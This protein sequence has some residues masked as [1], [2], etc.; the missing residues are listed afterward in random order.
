MR[1]QAEYTCD[2]LVVG[3]GLA[4][5]RG[6]ISAAEEGRSVLL[7]TAG[8]LFSGSSFYPGTWGLG[9]IG[10]DGVGDEEDLIDSICTLGRGMADEPLVRTFVR[11][12]NPA[13]EELKAMGVRLK[14]AENKGQKDFIP[15]FDRKHRSWN[16]ILFGS[17]REVFSRR[18]EELGEGTILSSCEGC[19]D[20]FRSKGRDTCHLL[21]LLF[22]RSKSRSW[23]NRF[24]TT[25]KTPIR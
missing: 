21:E 14:Q 23:G 25:R 16:G 1:L 2:V 5:I 6:A 17:A 3:T 24:H 8:K 12:I 7:C 4:G 15:C 19:L 20:A 9:L 18:L 13:V 11:G 22:G 10:P